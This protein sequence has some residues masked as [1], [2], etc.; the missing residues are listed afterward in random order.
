MHSERCELHLKQSL[1]PSMS[2]LMIS[3]AEKNST[4]EL[5]WVRNATVPFTPNFFAAVS[6]HEA[7][8]LRPKLS[9]SRWMT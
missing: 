2:G 3:L 9:A 7:H 5:S 8:A 4:T 1:M 6:P